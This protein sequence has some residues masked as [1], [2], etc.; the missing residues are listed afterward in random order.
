MSKTGVIKGNKAIRYVCDKFRTNKILYD[1]CHSFID[2]LQVWWISP[3]D[4]GTLL[5]SLSLTGDELGV[6]P[7][8]DDVGFGLG[9]VDDALKLD[10]LVLL[11]LQ[12]WARRYSDNLYL[13]R[14]N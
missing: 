5:V 2:L 9:L 6:L 10:D 1:S 11:D 3:L 7:E 12:A 14:R 8:P 13:A 4:Q